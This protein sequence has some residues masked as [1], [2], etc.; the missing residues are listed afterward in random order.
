MAEVDEQP[1]PE[2]GGAQVVHELGAVLIGEGADCLDFDDHL[3]ETDEV[4]PVGLPE[5]PALI[6]QANLVLGQELNASARQLQFQ[7]LLIH[8]F[9][10]SAAF[11]LIDLETAPEDPVRFL[12]QNQF[13]HSSSRV[14]SSVCSVSS[15]VRQ[16]T[17]PRTM[18]AAKLHFIIG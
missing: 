17:H 2:A 1:D 5:R 4:R 13:T 9:N 7:A 18:S 6:A 8:W 10:K 14:P 16:L 15:V 3:A 12:F 11:L